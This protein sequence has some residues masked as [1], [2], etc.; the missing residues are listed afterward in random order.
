MFLRCVSTVDRVYD[1]ILPPST[2]PLFVSQ[3]LHIA[4]FITFSSVII[5]PTVLKSQLCIYD[6]IP[7]LTVACCIPDS[8]FISWLVG[9]C[10]QALPLTPTPPW[11]GRVC[12]LPW[13]FACLIMLVCYLC[14]WLGIKLF[15][16]SSF[17]SGCYKHCP[18]V[19]WYWLFQRSLFCVAPCRFFLYL[20]C[21]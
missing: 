14:P 15:S 13:K 20:W 16:L 12:C 2:S 1:L 10:H 8:R 21:F 3:L 11:K 18:A 4:R 6:H 7:V 17:L 5:I 19:F 9:F